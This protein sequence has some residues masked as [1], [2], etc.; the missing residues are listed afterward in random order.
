MAERIKTYSAFFDFYLSEHT[1]AATRG[2]HYLG[3]ACGIAALV[4]TLWMLQPLWILVGL[5]V[6]YGCAWVG[7]FF[8]E[9]NR[10][11][12]FTYPLWSFVGDYHM[13][14]LW[15]TGGLAKRRELAVRR[16]P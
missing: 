12:T 3:S 7:H 13:F 11:A 15:L 2:L 4:L 9:H 16:A 5:V 10:P 1:K 6:G 14:F 8:I